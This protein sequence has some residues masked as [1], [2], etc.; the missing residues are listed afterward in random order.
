[1]P[2]DELDDDIDA[3]SGDDTNL[4]RNLRKQL[5]Q[6]KKEAVEAATIV[7]Q[8]QTEKRKQTVAEVLQG[9]GAPAG[10]AKFYTGEDAS[11]EAVESW[12]AENA[13]LFGI[14][15]TDSDEETN[16][17]VDA[18]SKVSTPAQQSGSSL[19]RMS[20]EWISHQFATKSDRELMD[21][22]LLPKM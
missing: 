7:A 3:D 15:L 12:L 10:I 9:K 1:M 2:N 22:G 4:V 18:V 21:L 17:Q 19:A 11:K 6:A 13:E 8:F 16:K 5:A 14:D 20:P